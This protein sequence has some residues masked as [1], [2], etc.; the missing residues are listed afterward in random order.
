MFNNSK[1]ANETTMIAQSILETREVSTRFPSDKALEKD[2]KFM[3]EGSD[4]QSAPQIVETLSSCGIKKNDIK[5]IKKAEAPYDAVEIE[6]NNGSVMS[7][8]WYDPLHPVSAVSYASQEQ[9]AKMV[10]KR[11]LDEEEIVG[12]YMI[13]SE[14]IYT[15]NN[16]THQGT[17]DIQCYDRD[18]VMALAPGEKPTYD[19][20]Y[21]IPMDYR[22]AFYSLVSGG[23][24]SLQTMIAKEKA[25]SAMMADQ[26]GDA[27]QTGAPKKS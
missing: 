17:I 1:P 8:T 16:Y 19:E 25:L 4:K 14:H 23:L 22:Q 11:P 12:G 15:F 3:K 9:S 27:M 10:Y 20:S 21:S 26:N 18:K 7:F 2:L 13:D 24:N 6:L 5:N